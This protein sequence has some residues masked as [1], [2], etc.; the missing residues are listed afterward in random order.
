M[1][2]TKHHCYGNKGIMSNVNDLLYHIQALR[3]SQK[4]G[5]LQWQNKASLITAED[6]EGGGLFN[7]H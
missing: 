4:A 7:Y 5:S 1:S 6:L 2:S 3:H